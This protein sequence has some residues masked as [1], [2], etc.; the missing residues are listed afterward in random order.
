VPVDAPGAAR[1]DDLNLFGAHPL[2]PRTVGRVDGGQPL[3]DHGQSPVAHGATLQTTGPD[4]C[5]ERDLH[6]VPSVHSKAVAPE[7]PYGSVVVDGSRPR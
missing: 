5:V 4:G 2:Q 1:T 3:L 7:E 6:H